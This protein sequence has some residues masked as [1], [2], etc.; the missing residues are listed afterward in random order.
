MIDISV[1]PSVKIF[2]GNDTNAAINQPVQ[3]K[4]IE[5]GASGVN[6]YS[7]F[8][9]SF[10]NNPSSDA[11]IAT[12]PSDITYTVVGTTPEGCQGTDEIR[13]KVY[14]G[15]DIYVPT[16][17]TPNNDGKNDILRAIPVGIKEF[18]FFKVFNRWGQMIFF[19][20]DPSNG[21]D[22]KIKGI[23]QPTSTYV[24]MAEAIDYT[25]KTIFKKGIITVIR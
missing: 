1:T 15:P 4:V 11:P 21:W 13:I 3:L 8:P 12:L 9:S 14:K 17:F 16:G 6:Q 20:K 23:N 22:G 25:G 7:W 10:L 2:A 19:T 24:W 5:L 18:R